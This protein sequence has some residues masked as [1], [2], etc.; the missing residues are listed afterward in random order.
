MR[1][2]FNF[3]R[4]YFDVFKELSDKDKLLFITALLEKQ[5]EGKEPELKGMANFA[6]LSQ[7]FNID[8]QVAGFE[9]KTGVKL[10]PT[11]GGSQGGI[12]GGSAQEE[13]KGKEEEKIEFS[14]FWELYGNKT[15]RKKCEA[16][17]NKLKIETQE[18]IIQTLPNFLAYK[19]FQ[20]YTHP[21][22]ETYLNNERWNDVI[23]LTPPNVKVAEAKRMTLQEAEALKNSFG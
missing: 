11:V 5:F 9:T 14:S 6:Y 20:N 19:P 3:Y 18:L 21:N 17:W 10:T 8:A 23:P 12:I 4:S 15:N 1:K 13:G 7:K 16:K 2:A 22:P